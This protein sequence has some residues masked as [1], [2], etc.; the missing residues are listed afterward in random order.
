[1]RGSE[2]LLVAWGVWLQRCHKDDRAVVSGIGA[3]VNARDTSRARSVA[4]MLDVDMG[5]PR[6]PEYHMIVPHDT[7]CL[8]ELPEQIPQGKRGTLHIGDATLGKVI[9]VVRP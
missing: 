5:F 2:V 9:I 6:S 7:G 1:M 8:R 4:P 3:V